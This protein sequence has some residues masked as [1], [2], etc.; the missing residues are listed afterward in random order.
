[1]EDL[2]TLDNGFSF[3]FN[4]VM[5]WYAGTLDHVGI[6][7]VGGQGKQADIQPTNQSK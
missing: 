6:S 7:F 1:M 4:M 5:A 2:R 3:V